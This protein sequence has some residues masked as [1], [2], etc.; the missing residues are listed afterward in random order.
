MARRHWRFVVRD[1]YGYVIQ[2][3]KVNVYQPGTSNAFTGTAYNAA[4][5]GGA[6]TNPFTTNAYGEAEAWFDNA[7][8][9]DVQVDDN[10]NLAYR[11]VGGA[12]DTVDF[13]TFTEKDDIYVTASEQATTGDAVISHGADRH[14]NIQRSF[15]L[16]VNDGAVIDGGALATLG[17]APDIIRTISMADAAT[18]GV[19]WDFLVPSD[20]D[21]GALNAEL[22]FVGATTAGGSIR[23][24]VVSKEV[25]EGA[26][27]TAAGTTV[28]QTSQAP[29]TAN[30]L[31]VEPSIAL[32]TPT[33]VGALV[34]LE[35]RRLG[36]DGADNYAAVAHMVGVRISYTANQ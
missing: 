6:V 27:V 16:P 33:V 34:K 15:W 36:A 13:A 23:L 17:T 19:S 7:Q 11:A 14:T 4:S 2:N 10:T 3:A 26:D 32:I 28:T 5:G 8:V 24:S 12:S 29:T 30:L 1:Q 35:A 25:A 18:S 20:W 21:S 22:Y 31:V 9:V